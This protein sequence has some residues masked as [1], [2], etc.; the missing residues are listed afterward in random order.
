MKLLL[1]NQTKARSLM[2]LENKVYSLWQILARLP[3][4]APP[5]DKEHTVQWGKQHR[6][7][8]IGKFMV[9]DKWPDI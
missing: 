8:E 7:T 6:G 9:L 2:S 5:P 1:L 3:V 4:N